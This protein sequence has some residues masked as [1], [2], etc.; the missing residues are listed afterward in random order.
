MTIQLTN[1]TNPQLTAKR[2]A[3]NVQQM[4]AVE[5]ATHI[6]NGTQPEQTR[7]EKIGNAIIATFGVTGMLSIIG[8]LGHFALTMN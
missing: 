6:M 3:L 7:G 4:A 8:V 1:D 5:I 2:V